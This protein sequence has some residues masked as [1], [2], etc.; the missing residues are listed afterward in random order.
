MEPGSGSPLVAVYGS[1]EA[2]PE[3]LARARALGG[4][5]ARAGYG[6]LN[7][8]YGGTME[9][10]AAGAR[11]AG[12]QAIGVTCVQF[13]FRSGPNR[14]CSE[15]IEAPTL[16]ARLQ[17]LLVRAS[18]YVVLPGGNGTLTELSLTWE[19]LRKGLIAERPLVV[20]SEP[21]RAIVEA[22]ADG[23]YLVGGLDMLTWVDDVEAAVRAIRE[24]VPV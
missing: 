15:V 7:G 22:L 10:A 9:A 23:D 4:S 12:G 8:G 16:T 11:E 18:A 17:E 19:H 3:D 20:W 2:P 24:R 6:I 13:S 14:H 21:W 1:G 5:L